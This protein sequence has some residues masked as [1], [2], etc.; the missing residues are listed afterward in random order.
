MELNLKGYARNLED[1]TVEIV[2]EG[3]GDDIKELIEFCNRSPGISK[4][5]KL[6]VKFEKPQNRKKL[7][8]VH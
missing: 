8:F 3:Q 5:S 7:V 1:G 2:A 6:D 4:V